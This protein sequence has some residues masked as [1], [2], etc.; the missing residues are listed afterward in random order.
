[1]N[2][3]QCK[4]TEPE[5]DVFIN[6]TNIL[7]KSIKGKKPTV[8]YHSPSALDKSNPKF[9]SQCS[10]NG[11]LNTIRLFNEKLTSWPFITKYLN[12]FGE[13]I[14]AHKRGCSTDGVHLNFKCAHDMLVML[15]D[16]NW[17]R[18]LGIVETGLRK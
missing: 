4:M 16:F 18:K 13:S 15:W 8:I 2:M 9:A 14:R 11:F 5:L 6:H 3:H 12:F 10:N 17:L 7:Y 1:M